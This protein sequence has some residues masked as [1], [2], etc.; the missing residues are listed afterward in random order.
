[1][2]LSIATVRTRWW[3]I[4]IKPNRIHKINDKIMN[5]KRW[6]TRWRQQ[7][8]RGLISRFF[9]RLEIAFGD[10][11]IIIDASR[12]TDLCSFVNLDTRD[13][14][15]WRLAFLCFY[16]IRHLF[17]F[18]FRGNCFVF[19]FCFFFQTLC[20]FELSL[21]LWRKNVFILS[22][23]LAILGR[24]YCMDEFSVVY[25][26]F[27]PSTVGKSDPPYKRKPVFQFSAWNDHS[28]VKR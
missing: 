9:I 8:W 16:L 5:Q 3:N 17:L 22:W 15:A 7:R 21:F 10:Y 28:F 20:H 27:V 25:E 2:R 11:N 24:D 12:T 23:P 14:N 4:R 26:T 13:V 6:K 19:V 1:M 18:I